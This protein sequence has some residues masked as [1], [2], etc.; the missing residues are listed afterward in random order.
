MIANYIPPFYTPTEQYR[1]GCAWRAALFF[2]VREAE[3]EP[4]TDDR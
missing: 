1:G 3:L 2:C 4:V